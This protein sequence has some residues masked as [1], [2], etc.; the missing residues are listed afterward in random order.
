MKNSKR[1]MLLSA[2]LT[3]PTVREAAANVGIPETTAYN[4]LREPEFA[5]EYKQRKRQL[6]AEASDFMQSKISAATRVIDEL[7][8][9]TETP[10]QTRLSAA[11]TI[12]ETAYKIFEQEEI[13]ERIEA[14]EALSGD[15]GR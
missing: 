15:S 8:T 11:K 9:D 14:L 13:I 10:P 4:W 3:N 12:I 1:E 7:M 2:L 6:V 5:D